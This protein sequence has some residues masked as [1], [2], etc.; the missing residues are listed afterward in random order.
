ME[1]AMNLFSSN[2]LTKRELVFKKAIEYAEDGFYPSRHMCRAVFDE[3]EGPPRFEKSN[4]TFL[5]EENLKYA[6]C[7]HHTFIHFKLQCTAVHCISRT[8]PH[9]VLIAWK[10]LRQSHASMQIH[11]YSSLQVSHSSQFTVKYA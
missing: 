4:Q 9:A 11:P 7:M 5:Y 8:C 6:P 3:D 10:A 2:T 1:E